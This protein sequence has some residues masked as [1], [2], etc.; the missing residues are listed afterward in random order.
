VRG[1]PFFLLLTLNGKPCDPISLPPKDKLCPSDH[2]GAGLGEHTG[3][4][5]DQ[6]LKEGRGGQNSLFV[7][8]HVDLLRGTYQDIMGSYFIPNSRGH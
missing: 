1:S 8:G 5:G 4:T 3:L 7:D 2:L 6:V